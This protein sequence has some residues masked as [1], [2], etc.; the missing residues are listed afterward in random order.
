MSSL[1]VCPAITNLLQQFGYN[2]SYSV[3]SDLAG[4]KNPQ[5]CNCGGLTITNLPTTTAAQSPSFVCGQTLGTVLE[6][7]I[8]SP[9]LKD[10]TGVPEQLLGDATKN[11]AFVHLNMFACTNHCFAGGNFTG[12]IGTGPGRLTWIDEFDLSN[13][14]LMTGTTRNVATQFVN[15][16]N[17]G[18]C[19]GG[20]VRCATTPSGCS[21]SAMGI[22]KTSFAVLGLVALSVVAL[23]A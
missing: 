8:D 22:P 2:V 17:T 7:R 18:V 21:S 5:L 4:N 15:N 9:P 13:N 19:C 20:G 12:L 6:V 10:Q 14:P 1:V 3:T 16:T 11:P 23:M